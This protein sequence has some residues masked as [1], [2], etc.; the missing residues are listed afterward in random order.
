MYVWEQA[1]YNIEFGTIQGFGH[2]LGSWN[3]G[4]YK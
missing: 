3:V 2:P 4:P 1:Y